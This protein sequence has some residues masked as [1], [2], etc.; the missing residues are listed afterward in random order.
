MKKGASIRRSLRLVGNKKDKTLKQEPLQSVT[1]IRVEEKRER[2]E[3]REREESVEIKESYTLPEIPLTPLSGE[4][5][6][7]SLSLSLPLFL[8]HTFSL[9]LICLIHLSLF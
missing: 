6:R 7:P 5:H 2:E 4:A 1:E 9:T 8:T 3:E